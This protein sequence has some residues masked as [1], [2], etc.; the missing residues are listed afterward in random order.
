MSALESTAAQLLSW[1]GGSSTDQDDPKKRNLRGGTRS[2]VLPRGSGA[3]PDSDRVY[4][5][6]VLLNVYDLGRTYL[7]RT[8]NHVAKNYGAFHTGLEVYGREWSFGMTF[9]DWS[10]GVTWNPPRENPDHRY[11]ET[12]VMGYTTLSPGKVWVLLEG[13]KVEWKGN[14]YNVLTRNCHHFSDCLST[15]LGTGHLPP[16]LNALA[17]TG[18]GVVENMEA[19]DSGYDGGETLFEFF[20]GIRKSLGSLFQ[21]DRDDQSDAEEVSRDRP[22]GAKGNSSTVKSKSGYPGSEN[23]DPVA[24][25]KRNS[26]VKDI[27]LI[28]HAAPAPRARSPDAHHHFPKPA[29]R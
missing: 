5:E 24:A 29:G 16:W 10:S 17:G 21:D 9:D 6:R 12:I 28:D 7:T 25:S 20:G 18:A 23:A 11:R 4:R 8:I 27:D 13:L 22:S 26:R 2:E 3:K 15:K 1:V 14:T 19:A